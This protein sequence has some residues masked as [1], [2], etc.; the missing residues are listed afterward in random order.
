MG[1]S[2]LAKAF[3]RYKNPY[4]F[5]AP[6]FVIFIVFQLFPMAWTLRISFTEWNG[7]GTAR[8]VGLGNYEM[9]F[10]DYMFWDAVRNT[11][12]YWITAVLFIIPLA[13]LM[14]V[15]LHYSR[16]RGKLFFKSITF[17]P[18]VCAA[19][20]MGLIFNVMF[21][22]N[23]GIINELLGMV[24]IGPVEWLTSTSMSKVPVVLLNVWRHTPW[25]TLII[26]SGLLNIPEDYY[27]S[28]RIDG[29]NALQQFVSITLPSLGHIL[30]FCFIIITVDSWN[31]F[32][33]PYILKGPS[34]SNISL[35]QYMYQSSFVL[36]KFGYAAAIGY[37]LTLILFIL[38]LIQFM[39]MRKQGEV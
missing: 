28:A 30:F 26:L 7:L 38:S 27:E 25:F 5:I 6:F 22:F 13:L 4:L 18:Y 23:S 32:T 35:F 17:F 34:T 19:V 3:K 16:L 1:G 37:M 29:A 24:G 31:I 36:F 8:E 10:R 11:L 14:S 33:E 20:A 2:S 39:L 15:L 9:L 12:Y 21:D